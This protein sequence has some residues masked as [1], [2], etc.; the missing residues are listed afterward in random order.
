MRRPDGLEYGRI[1]GFSIN[2]CDKTTWRTDAVKITDEA[3]GIG[4]NTQVNFNLAHGANA[5]AAERILDLNNGKVSEEND[6]ANPD[7]AFRAMGDGY[8]YP[9]EVDPFC[10]AGPLSG[11]VPIVMLDGVEQ[12]ER[13]FG[14]TE[15]GDYEIDYAQGIIT[16]F[17][18]PGTGVVVTAT[19]YYVP[20]NGC[21]CVAVIPAAGRKATVERL[22]VQSTADVEMTDTLI[23]N[24]YAGTPPSGVP[25][26]RPTLVKN[27]YDLVNW[28]HGSYVQIEVQGGA[29]P[30]G[31]T[32][33]VNIHRVEYLA[34]IPL[35]SESDYGP[36]Y[37]RVHLENG[38]EF[39]GTWATVVIYGI[40]EALAT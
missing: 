4:D 33:K 39:V 35:L 15:G 26:R 36:M 17:T 27:L 32:Q 7:G 3:V 38:V 28:A 34:D 8:K 40:D 23:M 29:A 16:F 30:R 13:P 24:V 25:L 11:Y 31:L 9:S 12:H 18:A 5:N 21:A 1:Y 19:Y 37:M 14:A 6:I 20:E 2:L 22:E 10:V